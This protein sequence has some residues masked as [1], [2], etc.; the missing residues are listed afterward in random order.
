MELLDIEGSRPDDGAN[1][2]TRDIAPSSNE[3]DIGGNIIESREELTRK[4]QEKLQEI[5]ELFGSGFGLAPSSNGS[6]SGGDTGIV[7]AVATNEIKSRQSK[8][9]VSTQR[10][11]R[12]P[13]RTSSQPKRSY[14]SRTRKPVNDSDVEAIQRSED[15]TEQL[16]ADRE[17][18]DDAVKQYFKTIGAIP[19]LT[20]E[21]EIYYARRYAN[22]DER[23]KDVLIDSNLRLVVSVAKKYMN[24]GLSLLDLIQEGNVGLIRAV[25][26]F[27]VDRGFK[28]S[29]YAT[30]WIRQAV[31]RALADQADLV[32]KPVHMIEHL[33]EMYRT[34]RDLRSDLGR[35]PT[36]LELA[37]KL[38]WSLDTLRD[39]K[40]ISQKP[41]SI[42]KPIAQDEDSVFGD[43]QADLNLPDVLDNLTQEK[44][45]E[46]IKR[47]FGKYLTPREAAILSG[48]YGIDGGPSMTLEELGIR[49]GV[50]RERIRQIENRAMQKLQRTAFKGRKMRSALMNIL[51]FYNNG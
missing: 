38:G 22:G 43:F 42:Q 29:T 36:D 51:S 39:R 33:T 45:V 48:R 49:L 15:F 20:P 1:D 9:V 13:V 41:I 17:K 8:P 18:L 14:P 21:E 26:K 35:E 2:V 6:E 3:E 19:L 12:N 5:D 34:S 4:I 32:R 44:I 10:S 50:T 24:R 30:W 28:L 16:D 46:V 27:E 11:S 7:R 40:K 37:S 25:E 23:A 47:W 31:S